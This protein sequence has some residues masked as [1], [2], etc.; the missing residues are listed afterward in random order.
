LKR[1]LL[2]THQLEQVA[3]ATLEL[4]WQSGQVKL[5]QWA[6]WVQQQSLAPPWEREVSAVSAL[7]QQRT[8]SK[9]VRPIFERR[10][11]EQESMSGLEIRAFVSSPI[12]CL[13]ATALPSLAFHF[14][15]ESLVLAE[16]EQVW[17]ARR[18]PARS[19]QVE[20]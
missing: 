9:S 17:L 18:A 14:S 4:V 13:L 7:M 20:V 10:P 1:G 2:R 8:A 5:E 16:L 11:A 19:A 12:F 6:R 3:R 15:A